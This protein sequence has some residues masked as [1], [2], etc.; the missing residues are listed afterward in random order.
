MRRIRSKKRS[1]KKYK[2]RKQRQRGGNATED[3]ISKSWNIA[4]QTAFNLRKNIW[5]IFGHN[6]EKINRALRRG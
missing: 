4:K 3:K 2:R 6:P 5:D 1:T